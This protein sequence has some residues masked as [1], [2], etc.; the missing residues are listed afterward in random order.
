MYQDACRWGLTLQTYVQ[1]TMLEQH[2][3]PQVHASLHGACKLAVDTSGGRA[4]RGHW[5]ASPSLRG[6]RGSRTIFL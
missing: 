1:L 5:V 6:R 4:A 2:T 3:R